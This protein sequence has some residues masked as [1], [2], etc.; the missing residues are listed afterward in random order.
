MASSDLVPQGA[1]GHF[2]ALF[3]VWAP[4]PPPSKHSPLACRHLPS[5][6]NLIRPVA[7]IPWCEPMALFQQAILL[8]LEP[9]YLKW[10]CWDSPIPTVF[11]NSCVHWRVFSFHLMQWFLPLPLPSSQPGLLLTP[12]YLPLSLS[13]CP[14]TCQSRLGHFFLLLPSPM[15]LGIPSSS[16]AS[17]GGTSLS[18]T[19]LWSSKPGFASWTFLGS[20][21]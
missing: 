21:K 14:P 8:S 10:T 20:H 3:S 4:K 2:W 9:E 12:S 7:Q 5:A 6:I 11:S 13:R 16:T 17:M 18:P 15:L 19:L 1:T